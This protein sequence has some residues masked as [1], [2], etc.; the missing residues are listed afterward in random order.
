MCVV[1]IMDKNKI[2]PIAFTRQ[3]KM[4]KSSLYCLNEIEA[5]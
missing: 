2:L 1:D 3:I 4:I 5:S